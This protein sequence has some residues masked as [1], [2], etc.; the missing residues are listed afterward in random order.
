[1]WHVIVGVVSAGALLVLS[2]VIAQLGNLCSLVPPAGVAAQPTP[3]GQAG[4]THAG[5]GSPKVRD[6]R[7]TLPK[8]IQ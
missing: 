3:P 1:M 2:P 8:R 7:V 5:A 6:G 4:H